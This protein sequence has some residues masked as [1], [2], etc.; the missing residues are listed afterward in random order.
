MTDLGLSTSVASPDPTTSAE[1]GH[2]PDSAHCDFVPQRQ[3]FSGHD[4][5]PDGRVPPASQTAEPRSDT[6]AEDTR[7]LIM[8]DPNG[9]TKP[10]FSS[11]DQVLTR[12]T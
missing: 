3:Q 8:P 12:Y 1:G 7:P 10:Q 2:Q 9:P 6:A 11:S 5:I 4:R